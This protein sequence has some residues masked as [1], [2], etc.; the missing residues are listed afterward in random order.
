MWSLHEKGEQKFIQVGFFKKNPIERS[1][2]VFTATATAAA[3]TND[4]VASQ[5]FV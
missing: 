2:A 3:T 4:D 1:A 5:C